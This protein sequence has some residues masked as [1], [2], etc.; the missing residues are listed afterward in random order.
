MLVPA[1]GDRAA[2]TAQGGEEPFPRS[3]EARHSPEARWARVPNSASLYQ[4]E[5]SDQGL[6]PLRILCRLTNTSASSKPEVFSIKKFPTFLD[7]FLFQINTKQ[8][9]ALGTEGTLSWEKVM[10]LDGSL[11]VWLS[12]LPPLCVSPSIWPSRLCIHIPAHTCLELGLDSQVGMFLPELLTWLH[13][14]G[15]SPGV[16][17]SP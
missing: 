15:L 6:F 7:P 14:P 12:L 10:Q 2:K 5:G 13:W 11:G 3:S 1:S 17:A 16:W 9:C 8:C 4:L